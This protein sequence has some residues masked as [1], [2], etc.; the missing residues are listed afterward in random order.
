M[1]KLVRQNGGTEFELRVDLNTVTIT[2][3]ISAVVQSDSP[4]CFVRHHALSY[5]FTGSG[6][7]SDRVFRDIAPANVSAY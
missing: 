5:E 1:G 3:V 7:K 2:G 6:D 4:L